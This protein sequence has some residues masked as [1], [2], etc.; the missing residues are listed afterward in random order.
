MNVPIGPH[1][2]GE[3]FELKPGVIHVVQVLPFCAYA[4]EVVNEHL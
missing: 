1:V 2:G 3:N 4:L